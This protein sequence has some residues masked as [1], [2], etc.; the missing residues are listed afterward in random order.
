MKNS[1]ILT[2]EGRHLNKTI[3]LSRDWVICHSHLKLHPV[4]LNIVWRIKVV[5]RPRAN[6]E[7]KLPNA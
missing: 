1:A 5:W 3:W 4:L 7:Q 2:C 6:T